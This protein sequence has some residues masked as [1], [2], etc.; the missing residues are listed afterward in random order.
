MRVAD[1]ADARGHRVHALL[2]LP[3][4]EHVLP[5]RVAR[6][7]VVDGRLALG[8]RRAR[9]RAGTRA[10]RRR[11]SRASSAPRPR[12]RRR[13]RR[14][15]SRRSRRGRGCRPGR[16][17]SARAPARRS[18]R[19]RRRSRRGR[20]RH[21]ISS[22]PA[23]STSASTLRRRGQ[24]A[25]HVGEERDAHLGAF[26]S[27]REMGSRR[28]RLPLAILG[29]AVAAGAATLLLRPRGGLIDP[30]AVNAKSYFTAF[31]LERAEDFR[32]L[33]RLIGVG[34]LVVGGVTLALLAAAPAARARAARAPTAA[35]RRRRR[36]PGI[37]LLLV[38]VELPL[39][40]WAHERAEDV[41]P[42]DP[43]LGAV[44]GRRRQ[45]GGHRRALRRR[46]RRASRWRWCGASAPLVDARRRR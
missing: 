11:S 14:C 24:V 13:S 37:S 21:Q 6:A 44:A 41:G 15:R 5:D 9:G 40:A 29:A 45:V 31:Q 18:R 32:E 30:A 8:G 27:V 33:Q 19:A 4:G 34:G 35:R 22:T 39:S 17:R 36:A 20:P 23:A 28:V 7:G 43:G 3:G 16:G 42:L 10:P 25:M 1:R 46:R 26:Y 2:G 38:V 12:R